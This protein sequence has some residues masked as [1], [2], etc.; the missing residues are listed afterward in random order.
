MLK[1][2]ARIME[3]KVEAEVQQINTLHSGLTSTLAC[4]A[5]LAVARLNGRFDHPRV[6][7]K[8][9]SS[10]HI[11]RIVYSF[12]SSAFPRRLRPSISFMMSSMASSGVAA[13]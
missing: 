8:Q 7:G 6:M 2:S 11:E 10:R 9:P 12:R 1:K 3:A 5:L 4:S 13:A